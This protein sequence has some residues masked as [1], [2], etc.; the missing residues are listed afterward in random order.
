MIQVGDLYLKLNKT[1]EAIQNF[2]KV[3][4]HYYSDGFF[5]KAIAIYKRI[6]KLEPNLTDICI[7][8]ADLYLKQGLTMD[9]KSQLQTVAHHYLSKNQNKDAIQTLQRL[10]EIE[11]ENLKTRNDLA[12]TYQKEGLV[13]EAVKEYMEISDQLARK[14]LLKES[15]AVLETGYKLDP[16]NTEILR[17]ILT[18]YSEHHEPAKAS[19]LLEE[20]V[21]LD[22][23][24]PDVQALM[25]TS[26]A[27]RDQ[28]EKAHQSIDRAIISSAKKEPYWTVKGDI[29]LKSGQLE[30]AFYQYAKVVDRFVQ[31]KEDIDQA[32]V[33]MQKI[34]KVDVS[35]HQ[36]WQKLVDL[37]SL[38][39]QQTNM[40]AAQTSLVDALISKNMYDEAAKNLEKL[41]KAE[42]EDSQHREK[43]RFVKSFI[44][45]TKPSF[46]P[47]EAQ[48]PEP[49]AFSKPGPAE[50]STGVPARETSSAQRKPA[51]A[52]PQQPMTLAGV[53]SAAAPSSEEKD[54][55]SEH[56]IE[57]E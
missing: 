20:A 11:P 32:V 31:R 25:A 21:R 29:Y 34:T 43:L 9:A 57:A 24:N 53:A 46:K 47:P 56:L 14:N 30:E 3:A 51:G 15:L 39:R 1:A 48:K 50:F 49:Q 19:A 13:P 2:L 7:R 17:K 27:E 38:L 28:P 5:L 23:N 18:L 22:P 33:L 54:F 52:H 40:I 4:D 16:R 12:R 6:N 42:P 26:F 35:F 55:V 37:F 10:I 8:L 45:R 41:I 44:E 36:A